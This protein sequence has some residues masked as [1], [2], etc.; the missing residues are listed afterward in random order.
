MAARTPDMNLPSQDLF[1][2]SIQ[3]VEETK[4]SRI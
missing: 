3:T 4:R 1:V 2:S